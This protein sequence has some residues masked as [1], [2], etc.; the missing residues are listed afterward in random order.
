MFSAIII[1]CTY[2]ASMLVNQTRTTVRSVVIVIMPARKISILSPEGYKTW[3][4]HNI[5]VNRVYPPISVWHMH[6]A[7]H[8]TF[9][10]SFTSRSMSFD[11]RI[12]ILLSSE[13]CSLLHLSS[14]SLFF[15]V[16]KVAPL[17]IN[18]EHFL[19]QASWTLTKVHVL[20]HLLHLLIS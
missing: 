13:M 2:S 15:E 17:G 5:L 8:S 7:H 1:A 18:C 3:W 11:L 12:F 10:F 16:C 19:S 4:L 9:D 14:T 20:L 6:E